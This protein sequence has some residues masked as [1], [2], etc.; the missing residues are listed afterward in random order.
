MLLEQ[1]AQ[2]THHKPV[3][4]SCLPQLKTPSGLPALSLLSRLGSTSSH[5][6]LTLARPPPV[7]L[8][9]SPFY[10]SVNPDSC[11]GTPLILSFSHNTNPYLTYNVLFAVFVFQMEVNINICNPDSS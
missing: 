7:S 11:P 4:T 1:K 10:S 5:R 3:G 8:C 6:A 9:P 2:G